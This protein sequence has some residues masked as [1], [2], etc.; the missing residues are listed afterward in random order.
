MSR[1]TE[2]LA[3]LGIPFEC[4][5]YEPKRPPSAPAY[6]VVTE[7]EQDDGPDAC[8]GFRRI[9]ALIELYDAGT[10]KGKQARRD[11]HD[12]LSDAN[13]KHVKERTIYFKD[14]KV[15]ETDYDI[16]TYIEKRSIR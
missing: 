9:S 13:L 5:G 1:V 4:D 3:A 14:E 8:V 6:A 12:A 15:F 7:V 16:D 10:P 11:L 2:V